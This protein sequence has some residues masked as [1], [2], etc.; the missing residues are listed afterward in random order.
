[1]LYQNKFTRQL[2][3]NTTILKKDEIISDKR[4]TNGEKE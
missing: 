4:E 1:M 2:S 3:D